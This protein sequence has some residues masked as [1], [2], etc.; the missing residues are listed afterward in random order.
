[1]LDELRSRTGLL[2]AG[3]SVVTSFLG[4]AALDGGDVDT[5]AVLAILVFLAVVG[6]S[7]WVLVPRTRAWRFALSATVLLED[8]AG[9]PPGGDAAAMQRFLATT[10]EKNWDHNDGKLQELYICFQ[11]TAGLLG[12]DVVLWTLKLA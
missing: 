1:M 12:L 10:I 4:A 7:L 8:W 5:L 9:D 2:L 6:L 11:I 3:A